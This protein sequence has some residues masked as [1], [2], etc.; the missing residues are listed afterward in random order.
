MREGSMEVFSTREIEPAGR[1]AAWNNR[2]CERLTAVDVDAKHDFVGTMQN[3]RVGQMGIAAIEGETTVVRGSAD[4]LRRAQSPALLGI[5]IQESRTARI[6]IG[7]ADHLVQEQEF[8][9]IDFASP[10]QCETGGDG[11]AVTVISVPS[12]LLLAQRPN[13][14]D[15]VGAKGSVQGGSG[16]LV[17]AFALACLKQ[18]VEID[19]AA[20][21]RIF[22]DLIVLL[23][24]SLD[25]DHLQVMTRHRVREEAIRLI[26]RHLCDP[27]LNTDFLGRRLGVSPRYIQ[28]LFADINQSPSAFIRTQ[29]LEQAREWLIGSDDRRI[30]EIAFD[31]GFGDLSQFNRSFKLRFGTPPSKMRRH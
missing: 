1:L 8:V 2:I 15:K 26:N 24:D 18:Q 14:M 7:S 5:A 19:A 30:S 11:K 9:L 28:M 12:H 10:Y 21:E 23:V 16:A 29:R 20:L 27:D 22:T 3:V 25:D 13:L 4:G 31:L 17:H 6:R